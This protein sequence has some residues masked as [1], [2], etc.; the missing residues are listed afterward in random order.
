MNLERRYRDPDSLTFPAQTQRPAVRDSYH[1][2]DDLATWRAQR[3]RH[4]SAGR[5]AC[6]LVESQ[7]FAAVRS[8]A[9]I[10]DRTGGARAPR[11]PVHEVDDEMGLP[12]LPVRVQCDAAGRVNRNRRAVAEQARDGGF[13]DAAQGIYAEYA[14]LLARQPCKV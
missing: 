4:L 3:Q 2:P 1:T 6:R 7:H 12:F 10:A 8:Q 5:H 14:V 9:G 13:H 11:R